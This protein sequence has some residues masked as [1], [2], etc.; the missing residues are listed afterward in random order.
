MV[1]LKFIKLNKK[2]FYWY[3]IKNFN[4][5]FINSINNKE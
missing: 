4:K 2:L 1:I 5:S 3:K